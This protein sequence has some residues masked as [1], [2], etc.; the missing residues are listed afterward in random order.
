MHKL[1]AFLRPVYLLGLLGIAHFTQAQQAGPL[2]AARRPATGLAPRAAKPA[3]AAAAPLAV[4]PNG[5]AGWVSLVGVL[6]S[7]EPLTAEVLGTGAIPVAS[8]TWRGLPAGRVQLELSLRS[9][10]AGAYTL[11]LSQNGQQWHLPLAVK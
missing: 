6:P 8:R 7:G 9:V 1:T 3:P 2:L 10:P 4:R 11:A 5:T